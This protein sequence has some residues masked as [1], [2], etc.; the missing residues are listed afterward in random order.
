MFKMVEPK[1]GQGLG[2][3]DYLTFG[4]YADQIGNQIEKECVQYNGVY[5]LPRGGLP[6]AV[7]LAHRLEVQY[8]DAPQEGCLIVDDISDSGN[9]LHA[10]VNQFKNVD[11][12]T[13]F[14]KE[15]SLVIPTYSGKVVGEETWVVF[16]WEKK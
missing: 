12:A 16:P 10:I 2:Y 4:I 5:G 6:L 3:L 14:Y 1:L 7:H 9:T 15:N 8:L 13:I 11:V